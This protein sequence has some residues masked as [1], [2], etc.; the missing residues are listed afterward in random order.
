M[1]FYWVGN[2]WGYQL[3]NNPFS[4]SMEGL[5]CLPLTSKLGLT[6]F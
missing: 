1:T 6:V 4:Y 2:P 5:M 3:N